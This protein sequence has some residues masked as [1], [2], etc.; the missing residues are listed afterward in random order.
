LQSSIAC[1]EACA[2]AQGD[3]AKGDTICV[4]E[5][6][7][8]AKQPAKLAGAG[9]IHVTIGTPVSRAVAAARQAVYVLKANYVCM[10]CM[11]SYF[12]HSW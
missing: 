3:Q 8:N 11:T 4:S 12:R 7:D 6:R 2:D 9:Y 5:C 1:A 10:F